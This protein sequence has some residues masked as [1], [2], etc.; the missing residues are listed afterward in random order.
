[1]ASSLTSLQ[2]EK[3]D[4]IAQL[5]NLRDAIELS[6]SNA[7]NWQESLEEMKSKFND[8]VEELN[9]CNKIALALEEEKEQLTLNSTQL[10]VFYVHSS[11]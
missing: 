7:Q 2:Q 11:Y 6:E 9:A 10:Q 1:M 5:N 3:A 8:K 4:L